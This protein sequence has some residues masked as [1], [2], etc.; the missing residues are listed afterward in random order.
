MPQDRY[1]ADHVSR[2]FDEY[3]DREWERLDATLAERVSFQIHRWYLREY[4]SPE[5]RVL[6]L[7]AG[8]GRY[9]MELA[10]L[11]AEVTV[12]DISPVQLELH[13]E[14]LRDSSYEDAVVA[15]ELLDIVDLSRFPNGCFDAVVCYGGPLSYV[16]DRA[17][18]ALGEIHRVT[19]QGGHILLSVMSLI[20]ATRSRFPFV[21][22]IIGEHGP[23]VVQKVID[24]GD[25]DGSVSN[26][27]RCHMYRWS[28]LRDLLESFRCRIVAASASNFL[29]LGNERELEEIER[30][31]DLWE[32][33]IGWELDLCQEPGAIDGG[34]HMIVVLRKS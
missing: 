20:G 32:R 13:R 17:D 10:K 31:R 28:E 14:R 22:D 3:A 26:G 12:G 21:L 23:N 25:L 18:E 4:V 15:R 7:G 19:R 33:F 11:G 27:H 30:D 29:S 6:E 8:P 5:E 34:T 2:Y 1:D 9:T 24:T 16:M